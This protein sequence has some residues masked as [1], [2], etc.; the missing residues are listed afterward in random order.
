MT[1]ELRLQQR[2]IDELEFEPSVGA[3]HI[4]VS[5]RQGVVTLSGH[6]DSYAEKYAAERATRRVRGVTAIAEELEV[7][8]PPDRKT[9][10]DEIAARA[11]R[12]LTW[13]VVLPVGALSVKVEH[14]IVTLEGEVEWAYQRAEAEHDV[15]RLGGVKDV[16]NSILVQPQ[17][18]S[19]DIRA[20]IR[21]AFERA[22]DVDA[23]AVTVQV[24]NGRVVLTGTVRSW[25]E[26]EEA[27]RA[28]ISARGVTA[29]ENRIAIGRS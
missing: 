10:D 8:L 20:Q 17:V 19:E 11:V 13:D 27:E 7:R 21:A 23:K 15:R 2:V 14:G 28:A 4:G 5:V 24:T 16:I 22:A 25:I 9:A 3:A 29:V 18:R 6:V 12:L 26:R 1:E